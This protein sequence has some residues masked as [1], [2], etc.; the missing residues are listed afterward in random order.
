MKRTLATALCVLAPLSAQAGLFEHN[1][2]NHLANLM[3]IPAAGAIY[4]HTSVGM[5]MYEG[6][7]KLAD[8]ET[9]IDLMHVSQELRYGFSDRLNGFVGVTHQIK[10]DLDVDT[11][12]TTTSSD[13]DGTFNPTVGASYRIGMVND[14]ILTSDIYFAYTPDLFDAETDSNAQTENA[15]SPSLRQNPLG[16]DAMTLGAR[17]GRQFQAFQFSLDLAL[18]RRGER[19]VKNTA[20]TTTIDAHMATWFGA[21]VQVPMG[22]GL[23]LRGSV[24]QARVAGHDYE[25]AGTE[26]SAN[27]ERSMIYGLGALWALTPDRVLLGADVT[28]ECIGDRYGNGLKEEGRKLIGY[29]LSARYQF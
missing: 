13:V 12:G 29:A 14:H 23:W 24:H 9:E 20:D 21:N 7:E 1:D 26:D 11:A 22:E 15:L 16:G 2:S 8:V 27:V 5:G 28:Y 10:G 3:Y 6:K 19:E 4:G 25:T 17:V 18:T